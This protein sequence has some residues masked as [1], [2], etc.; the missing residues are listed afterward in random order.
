[1]ALEAHIRELSDRHARLDQTIQ[2]V[3]RS[4]ASDA[5]EIAT[6]KRKKLKLKEELEA[7]RRQ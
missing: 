4:P 3:Q 1:M 2:Q 7:L 5:I 6:L